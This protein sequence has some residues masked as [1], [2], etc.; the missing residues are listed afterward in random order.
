MGTIE[1]DKEKTALE[2]LEMS[3]SNTIKEAAEIAD[4]AEKL[5]NSVERVPNAESKEITEA[6]EYK[7]RL[8]GCSIRIE[9]Y[10]STNLTR[11]RN[12]LNKLEKIV[13]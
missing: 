13:G 6:E 2:K 7:N 8:D 3:I 12:A 1:E 5:L 9:Q 11:I 10:L 4:K